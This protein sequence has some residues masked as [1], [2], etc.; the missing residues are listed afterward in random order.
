MRPKPLLKLSR[1]G[2]LGVLKVLSLLALIE[3]LFDPLAWIQNINHVA[4]IRA[5]LPAAASRWQAQGIEDYDIQVKGFVPLSCMI[6]AVLTVRSNE[7]AAV[8]KRKIPWDETSPWEPAPS[9]DWDAPFCSY[10]QLAVSAMFERVRQNLAAAD[11]S[12]DALEVKFD[13]TYGFVASYDH[14]TGY[15]QGFLNPAVSECCV[16][17]TFSNFR[18]F[19][20]K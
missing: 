10:R 1:P 5:E 7:L 15:R 13:P 14:R 6:E 16:W 11:L 2:C 18:A 8:M 19:D 9:K 4:Q 12:M 20:K 17:Y 3:L